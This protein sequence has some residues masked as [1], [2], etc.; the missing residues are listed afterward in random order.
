MPSIFIHMEDILRKPTSYPRQAA[1]QMATLLGDKDSPGGITSL[2]TAQ[3]I[4]SQADEGGFRAPEVTK[5]LV[6][7]ALDKAGL[8]ET[9]LIIDGPDAKVIEDFRVAMTARE[10]GAA[11]GA[12]KSAG[13]SARRRFKRRNFKKS[14]GRKSK[15][16]RS[17]S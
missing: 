6:D 2:Y 13:G 1:A 15:R 3:R 9:Y 11:G 7:V 12:M 16:R 10:D 17:R 14:K 8:P 4:Y 5:K